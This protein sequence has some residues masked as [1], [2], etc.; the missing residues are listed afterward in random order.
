MEWKEVGGEPEADSW[1]I[2]ALAMS[3]QRWD[4]VLEGSEDRFP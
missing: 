4:G 3:L 2:F 1:P